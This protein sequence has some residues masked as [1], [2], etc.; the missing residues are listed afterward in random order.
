VHLKWL[1]YDERSIYRNIERERQ[2]K[3]F[4]TKFPKNIT[5]NIVFGI[6]LA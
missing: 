3:Y 2:I 4:P 1:L 6:K 5:Q